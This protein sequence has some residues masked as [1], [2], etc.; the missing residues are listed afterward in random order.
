MEIVEKVI[1]T[2]VD[3]AVKHGECTNRGD[4][5]T[6]NKQYKIMFKSLQQ[7]KV[8]ED[9]IIQFKELMEHQSDYVRLWSSTHLLRVEEEKAKKHL[10]SLA[11]KSEI[12]SLTAQ[13]TLDEWEK[14]NLQPE[15]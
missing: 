11:K 1:K 2:F 13:T 4:Y 14:G 9:G 7:L 6:A 10:K 3:A 12:I 8:H 15:I 5:R